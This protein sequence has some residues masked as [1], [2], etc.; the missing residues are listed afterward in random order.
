MLYNVFFKLEHLMVPWEKSKHVTDWARTYMGWWELPPPSTEGLIL[1]TELSSAQGRQGCVSPA[2]S[3]LNRSNK[4]QLLWPSMS[5]GDIQP[6]GRGMPWE[7]Q[8]C[9]WPG[10]DVLGDKIREPWTQGRLEAGTTAQHQGYRLRRKGCLDAKASTVV[11]P[12][13]NDLSF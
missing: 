4:H 3:L 10:R 1:L 9:L 2:A 13:G 7:E 12:W 11:W 6:L 8:G 5:F